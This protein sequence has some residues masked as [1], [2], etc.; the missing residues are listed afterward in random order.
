MKNYLSSTLALSV[1]LALAGCGGGGDD[2]TT[3]TS[4]TTSTTVSGTASDGYLSGSTVCF[5]ANG[6]GLC[7]VT[8][9]FQI[10]DENGTY[11]FP[12]TQD[13]LNSAEAN[14]SLLVMGGMDIDS[15]KALVGSLRAPYN[16]NVNITPLSTMAHA[17]VQDKSISTD[18][19]Y[20]KV[21]DAL[22]LT[23]EEVTAD[24]VKLAEDENNTKVIAASMSLNRIVT[25]LAKT[26][27]DA[28]DA[29]NADDAVNSIYSALSDAIET[30]A[31]STDTN[32]SVSDVFV[33][34]ASDDNS[35]LPDSVKEAAK[36][37]PVIETQVTEAVEN[38]GDLTDAA[39]L[40]DAVVETIQ[41]ELATA[42]ENNETIDDTFLEALEDNA[43]STAESVDLVKTAILNVF[44][45]YKVYISD[46]DAETIKNSAGFESSSDVNAYAILMKATE[47]VSVLSTL[48]TYYTQDAIK[49]YLGEFGLAIS[50][51]GLET[52]T[53]FETS[54][55]GLTQPLFSPTMDKVEFAKALYDTGDAELMNL[56]LKIAPPENYA[57]TTDVQKAKDLFTSLRTQANSANEYANSE[58]IEI[59][60]ALNDVAINLEVVTSILD[61]ITKGI[62]YAMETNQTTLSRQ[63]SETRVSSLTKSVDSSTVTW[64]YDINQTIDG[65]ETHWKGIISYPDADFDNFDPSSFEPLH[66]V[67]EGDLPLDFEAVNEEGIEDKQSVKADV[68]ITKTST[69]SDFVLSASI[70]S[71][72]DSYALTDA[73]ASIAYTTDSTTGEPLPTYVKL[74]NLYIDGTVGDYTLSGKLDVNSYAQN[75]IMAAAGGAEI[76]TTES[77]INVGF[78]CNNGDIIIHE[79]IPGFEITYNGNVYYPQYADI[80]NSGAY[81]G[82]EINEGDIDQ[83]SI[84]YSFEVVCDDGQDTPANSDFNVNS[85]T[86][87][88]PN[89]SGYLPS[90]LSF[91]GKLTNNTNSSYFEGSVAAKWS[92][93]ADANLSDEDYNPKLQVTLNG[94]LQMP[95][96][97]LM[98]LRI[99][100]D[101]SNGNVLDTTYAYGD[102]SVTSHNVMDAT[103]DNGT[104][105]VN[106]STGIVS[107][108]KLV[109][110]DIDYANSTLT[111]KDGK[112]IGTYRETSGV[113]TIVYIDGTFE[114]L[115]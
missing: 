77:W 1:I 31:T 81:F 74:N 22:G 13:L 95:S 109:D 16:T 21:A 19:A 86:E 35:T 14:A 45:Y 88:E 51:N 107:T 79:Q 40:A 44:D 33:I 84:D 24:P 20:A 115:P 42:I 25:S 71:N 99:D 108:I 60:N 105:T 28:G 5:D 32:K 100:F 90:D 91:V 4:A 58:S 87:S 50:I 110:G 53:A 46:T 96:S 83:Y 92:D 111:T 7:D 48:K 3:T 18:E 15:K 38:S 55:F 101:N 30:A 36:A 80:H 8:E 103:L 61:S 94:K 12:V 17:L 114:S 102:L 76:E 72:G 59:D 27:S 67:L 10:T 34:V 75:K 98:S 66:A 6:N 112:I 26:A 11:S 9:P 62:S 57:T 65:S 56:S 104:I 113:P 39:V 69:G 89:N 68:T 78:W 41:T 52:L 64:A 49:R 37:A 93:A 82:Y 23:V 43:T 73:K 63:V 47:P 54:P 85:W 70:S 2:S 106:A 29:A 97:P